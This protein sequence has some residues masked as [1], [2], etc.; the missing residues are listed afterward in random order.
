M[1]SSTHVLS[2]VPRWSVFKSAVGPPPLKWQEQ[3]QRL[4]LSN[5]IR[6]DVI[7]LQVKTSLIIHKG[8]PKESNV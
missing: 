6:K 4:E 8:N 7:Y 5:E 2:G 3:D 1:T